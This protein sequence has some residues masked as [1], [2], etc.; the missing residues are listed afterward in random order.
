MVWL[1]IGLQTQLSGERGG[2]IISYSCPR[3]R[4]ALQN[5]HFSMAKGNFF[6]SLNV[7]H[8][9]TAAMAILAATGMLIHNRGQGARAGPDWAVLGPHRSCVLLL[10]F[11]TISHLA[12]DMKDVS[13]VTRLPAPHSQSSS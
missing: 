10:G 13:H 12:R 2:I 11:H 3:I 9:V 4:Q 8:F 7:G 6:P 1:E 5:S